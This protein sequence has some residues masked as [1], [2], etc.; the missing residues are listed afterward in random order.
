MIT[1]QEN[2]KDKLE[3]LAHKRALLQSEQKLEREKLEYE[4]QRFELLKLKKE[5]EDAERRIE[6][7]LN[8][9]SVIQKEI[10]TIPTDRSQQKRKRKRT[11]SVKRYRINTD[12]TKTLVAVTTPMSCQN[13]QLDTHSEMI[14]RK[15]QSTK[16]SH[17]INLNFG[18]N[19]SLK[20]AQDGYQNLLANN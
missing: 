5:Q 13:S 16:A 9:L 11:V 6:K 18:D 8:D 17:S 12:G 3:L 7:S 4:K 2:D 15:N 1:Q 14:P 19:N 20:P 10:G